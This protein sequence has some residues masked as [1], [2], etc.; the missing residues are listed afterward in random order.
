VRHGA[1]EPPTAGL[2]ASPPIDFDRVRPDGNLTW[3]TQFSRASGVPAQVDVLAY[4]SSP[5]ACEVL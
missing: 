4:M 1:G 3:W 2:E 5:F